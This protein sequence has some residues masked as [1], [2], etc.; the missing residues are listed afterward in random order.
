MVTNTGLSRNGYIYRSIM[1]VINHFG[2]IFSPILVIPGYPIIKQLLG[3]IIRNG[4]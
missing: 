1:Y 3:N 4:I 2:P